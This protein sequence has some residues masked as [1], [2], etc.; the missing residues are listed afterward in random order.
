M[1][2]ILKQKNA[3]KHVHD[4]AAKCEH[5]TIEWI[6]KVSTFNIRPPNR[7]SKVKTYESRSQ[8]TKVKSLRRDINK[9]CID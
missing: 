4:R 1:V 7:G 2:N 3:S 9:I 6:G 8:Y 5:K